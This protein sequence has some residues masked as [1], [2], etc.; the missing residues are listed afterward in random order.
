MRFSLRALDAWNRKLHYY[1][2]LYLLLFLWLFAVSGLLLNHPQWS[3]ANFWPQ[4]QQERFERPVQLAAG[5]SDIDRARSL[6][7]Q[8]GLAGEIEWTAPR[9]RPERF[10]FR[11]ARPGRMASVGVNV[12][13]GVASVE[14]ISVNGWG[15][16]NALHSFT[17]VRAGRPEA[18]RDW[19]LTRLW[20]F[21]M[22]AACVGI[23][24]MVLSGY[25]MWLRSRRTVPGSAQRAPGTRQ[26]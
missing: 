5:A 1:S 17:G 12:A 23:V 2:G 13:T 18:T 14:R 11:V 3:V 25:W 26:G 7:R 24:F 21:S 16:L 10:E 6:M 4:R 20:S 8:L 15:V 9:Q 19:W 22:D